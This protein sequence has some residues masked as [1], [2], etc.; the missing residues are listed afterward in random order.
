MSDY[1]KKPQKLVSKFHI[2]LPEWANSYIDKIQDKKLDTS[3]KRASVAIELSRL[4]VKHDSGGPFGTVI[5]DSEGT[6]LGI[7]VNRVVPGE[8][9]MLHG[10]IVALFM[11]QAKTNS[12]T[13]HKQKA[14]LTTS[15]E[16]CVMC[17]GALNWPGLS[18]L[19]YCASSTNVE[20]LTNF[21]E[22]PKPINWKKTLKGVA[23]NHL[24]ESE[25]EACLVLELYAKNNGF[26]Y[27]RDAS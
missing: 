16:P 17:W 9:S 26:I 7:G 1:N 24:K 2:K 21:D 23:V 4:N 13:L 18:L 11:A 27:N 3:G 8:S 12:F 20:L 19:E 25:H 14:I 6:I 15:A 10:E 5:T 22:G